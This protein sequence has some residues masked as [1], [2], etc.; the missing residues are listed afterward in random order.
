MSCGAEIEA[1]AL[2]L[3]LTN[4]MSFDIP[5]I[6]LDGPLFDIPAGILDSM[7]EK[8]VA[9]T[10]EDVTTREVGGSGSFDAL[11][12]S[13]KIHLG[14]EYDK[15]RITGAEYTKAYIELTQAAMGNAVQ[16][17][18]NKTQAFWAA[19]SA[20]IAAI[21]ARVAMNMAKVELIKVRSEAQL[22]KANFALAKVKLATESM[23]Y[24]IQ[25]Y[26]LETMLP[27]QFEIGTFDKQL[28]NAQLN[29]A[30]YQLSNVLPGQFELTQAQKTGVDVENQTKNYNLS[31]VL[32]QQ[33]GKLAAEKQL[34]EYQVSTSMPAQVT[35]VREQ[36]EAQRAQTQDTRTDGSTILGV[37]G[38]QKLLYAQQITSYQRDSEL[39]AAKLFTDAWTV[40]KT[41]DEGLLPPTQFAN[42]SLDVVLG[43]IKTNN[44]LS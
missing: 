17:A 40:Q 32:P 34:A 37:L 35:L 41:I 44:N 18:L 16:F 9:V 11:M 6:D 33:M 27:L 36:T 7:Y 43:H 2:L 10:I 42:A 3:A 23:S 4:G 31:T 20:Q 14:S 28:K 13:V 24:C 12:E 25:K 30:N 8:V 26:N 1:E 22:V 19:Q 38:K 29:T 15:G 39:K 21:T 5:V